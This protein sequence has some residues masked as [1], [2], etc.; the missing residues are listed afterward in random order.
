[1]KPITPG[2]LLSP[3]E[4]VR[5]AIKDSAERQ[6]LIEHIAAQLRKA[7]RNKETSELSPLQWYRRMR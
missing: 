3:G 1:M 7:E 4:S 5:L 2:K 6:V